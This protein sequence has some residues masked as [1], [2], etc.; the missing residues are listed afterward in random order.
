MS[1]KIGTSTIYEMFEIPMQLN[2]FII[3]RSNTMEQ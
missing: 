3:Y 1:N 2:R